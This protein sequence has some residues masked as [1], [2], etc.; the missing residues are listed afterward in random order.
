[1]SELIKQF[2]GKTLAEWEKW[3]LK[4]KS[5]AIEAATQKILK[6]LE[7]LKG[8]IKKIDK[9]IIEQWVRDLVIIKTFV[10]L[11]FQEIILKKGAE[12]KRTTYRLSGPEEE[13]KGIDGYIGN[14]PV[15]IK[16]YTY[17][18]KAALPENIQVK[19]IYYKKV[20]D[21]LEVD[22]GEIS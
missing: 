9:E 1:M 14:I 17:K 5:D 18:I 22:Y 2:P 6:N 4:Q 13:S 3:Y 10:G 21:G 15:S 19:I 20:K 12:I 8:A 7:N 16:P 11:K